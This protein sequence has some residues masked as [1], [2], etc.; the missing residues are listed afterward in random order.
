[1]LYDENPSYE[2]CY[3]ANDFLAITIA[4]NDSHQYFNQPG[5]YIKFL[6]KYRNIFSKFPT[7]IHYWFRSELSEPVGKTINTNGPRLH[8]HGMVHLKKKCSVFSFLCTIMPM[9]LKDAILSVNHIK[10]ISQY[11]GCVKYMHKQQ[12]YMPNESVFSNYIDPNIDFTLSFQTHIQRLLP[13][14]AD[15]GEAPVVTDGDETL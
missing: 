14:D 11:E 10:S 7:Y 15:Q 13:E 6:E 9:L 2:N 3:N 1:M 8:L 5:R 12:Q 4:P